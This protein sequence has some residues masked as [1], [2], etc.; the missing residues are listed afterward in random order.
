MRKSFISTRLL[1]LL[2][3][4]TCVG[5]SLSCCTRG[6]FACP[7]RVTIVVLPNDPNA[8]RFHYASPQPATPQAGEHE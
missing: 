5:G 3:L 2:V 1:L 4:G 7:R 8:N 6:R